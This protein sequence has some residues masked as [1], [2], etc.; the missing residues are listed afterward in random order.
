MRLDAAPTRWS[1]LT[2]TAT[3]LVALAA[4]SIPAAANGYGQLIECRATNGEAQ[5]VRGVVAAVVASIARDLMGTEPSGSAGAMAV[6]PASGVG[7]DMPVCIAEPA[8]E[9]FAGFQA[10]L[11]ERLLDLPPPTC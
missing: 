1:N 8:I 5:A 3:T 4:M 9:R 6:V 10:I 7:L 11:D 2:A